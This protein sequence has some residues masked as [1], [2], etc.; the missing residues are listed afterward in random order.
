MGPWCCGCSRSR[1]TGGG[2]RFEARAGLWRHRSGPTEP[3]VSLADLHAAA[4]GVPGGDQQRPLV[5]EDALAGYLQQA[6]LLL[7]AG[8]DRLED[9]PTGLSPDLEALRDFHL[10]PNGL[11]GS[12]KARR[13]GPSRTEA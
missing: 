5:G 7:A 12:P 11:D 2:F 4:I 10:P 13:A 8:T 6:R 3:A 1:V 9:E